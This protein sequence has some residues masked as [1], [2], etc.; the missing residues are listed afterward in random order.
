MPVLFNAR[1]LGDFLFEGESFF[2]EAFLGDFLFE[3]ESFFGEAFLGDF[4]FEGES[5]FGEAFLGDFLFE[6]ESFFGEAF[7]WDSDFSEI[8][9]CIET[10]FGGDIFFISFGV[11]GG[12]G[13]LFPPPFKKSK[14][15]IKILTPSIWSKV[16]YFNV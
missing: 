11:F 6:G 5:F 13:N 15:F 9:L 4:L 12:F 16:T 7:L 14:Y 8:F 1:L 3:G 10:L 2:G